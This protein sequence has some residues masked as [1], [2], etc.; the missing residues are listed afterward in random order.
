MDFFFFFF[1]PFH[2]F[3]FLIKNNSKVGGPSRRNGRRLTLG[4]I[5]AVQR[6]QNGSGLAALAD[7]WPAARGLEVYAVG[8]FFSVRY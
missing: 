3:Y 2:F 6:N 4:I 1:F 8:P 5:D 7:H